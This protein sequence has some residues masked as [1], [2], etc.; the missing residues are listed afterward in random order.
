MSRFFNQCLDGPY[1]YILVNEIFEP[2]YRVFFPFSTSFSA[3]PFNISAITCDVNNFRLDQYIHDYY[4]SIV[5]GIL[6]PSFCSSILDPPI[7]KVGFYLR[8]VVY[9]L[10][11]PPSPFFREVLFSYGIHLIQLCPKV[12]SKVIAF[13]VFCVCSYSFECVVVLV[14]L[15]FEKNMV[16]RLSLIAA[17]F[18]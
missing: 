11:L 15:S 17:I 10:R 12:L 7:G 18:P 8:H 9:C 13:E 5:H 3:I 16:T 2:S 4:L 6:L 14:L 1:L